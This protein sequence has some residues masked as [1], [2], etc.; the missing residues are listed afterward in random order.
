MKIKTLVIMEMEPEQTF[1]AILEL[2]ALEYEFLSQAHGYVINASE[3]NLDKE[4]ASLCISNAFCTDPDHKKYSSR[5]QRHWFGKFKN[6]EDLE[7]IEGF[8]KLIHTS[9]II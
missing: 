6:D 8:S 4:E 5:L 3:F 1:K 7:D 9:I 2:T